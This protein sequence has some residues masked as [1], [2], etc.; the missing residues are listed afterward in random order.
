MNMRAR[1][2]LIFCVS[3]CGSV[4]PAL[5]EAQTTVEFAEEA[6]QQD[7]NATTAFSLI[8]A[9]SRPSASKGEIHSAVEEWSKKLDGLGKIASKK[10][11]KQA[12]ALNQLLTK[13]YLKTFD[14]EASFADAILSGSHSLTG[15]TF[16]YQ[17]SVD[18]LKIPY[19]MHIAPDHGAIA[20]GKGEDII[21]LY[22]EHPNCETNDALRLSEAVT[23]L[24]RP[25]DFALT[26]AYLIASIN[27]TDSENELAIHYAK[28]MHELAGTMKSRQHFGH[29]LF[30]AAKDSSTPID[31]ALRYLATIYWLAGDE[32]EWITQANNLLDERIRVYVEDE[33]IFEK[34]LSL[35]DNV[36]TFEFPDKHF[37]EAR[38]RIATAIARS[39]SMRNFPQKALQWYVELGGDNIPFRFREDVELQVTS[40]VDLALT[41]Q[42]ALDTLEA[43]TRRFDWFKS[44]QIIRSADAYVRARRVSRHFDVGEEEKGLFWLADLE[45]KHIDVT[46]IPRARSIIGQ[47]YSDAS[48]FYV[49]KKRNEEA[50]AMLARGLTKL[51]EHTTMLRRQKML[52]DAE[53]GK[54]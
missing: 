42:A 7:A 21:G 12:S 6:Y 34:L 1:L 32:Q 19:Q 2:L 53:E 36:A 45:A 20:L 16:L 9:L 39:Y 27:L 49:R 48:A 31:D 47:A 33:T 23:Q 24:E 3:F 35:Y 5:T 28:R 51:P 54:W 26:D 10:A 30:V 46:A 52:L 38:R 22:V 14:E 4:T 8:Y 25:L 29:T 11:S 43:Y 37:F 40:L 15:G 44:S 13:T 41:D 18:Y 17:L 50:K